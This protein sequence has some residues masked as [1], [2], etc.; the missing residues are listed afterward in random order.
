MKH[1]KIFEEFEK[2]NLIYKWLGSGPN[3]KLQ[4]ILIDGIKFTPNDGNY[5]TDLIKKYPYSI[6]TTRNKYYKYGPV[7]IR[8]CLDKS[9]I[10]NKY[11]VRPHNYNTISKEWE[12]RIFSKKD[13]YLPM[14]T[15]VRIECS[16]E[17]YEWIKKLSN[18]N[19][20]KIVINDD[21]KK[22]NSRGGTG[23]YYA[24]YANAT[25]KY[26]YSQKEGPVWAKETI[27][28]R[29]DRDSNWRNYDIGLK[30]SK[31]QEGRVLTT[32]KEVEQ[33]L[34]FLRKK[35]KIYT[36]KLDDKEVKS[37]VV[38]DKNL[39]IAGPMKAKGWATNRIYWDIKDELKQPEGAIR[40]AIK[41]F[42]DE[43]Q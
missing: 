5:Y 3:S 7:N 37:I 17:D 4:D 28:K 9:K 20:I 43:Q 29:H 8:I 6:S 36:F 25:K 42:I 11:S 35:Y 12:D 22:L 41:N 24:P 34:K 21:L 19:N 15:V 27:Q 26:L 40:R 33:V 16:T 1:L 38:N 39:I 13:G 18:P 14:N 31:I 2:E 30:K 10:S 23:D 32:D